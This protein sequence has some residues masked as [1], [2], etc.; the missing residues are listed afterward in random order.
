MILNINNYALVRS[1]IYYF[2]IIALGISTLLFEE[3]NKNIQIK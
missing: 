2:L 1:N 3:F